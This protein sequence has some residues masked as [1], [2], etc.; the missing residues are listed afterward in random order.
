MP[1]PPPP[2][3]L[4][5]Q[6]AGTS[7]WTSHDGAGEL[8]HHF[9]LAKTAAR[10]RPTVGIMYTSVPSLHP[11]AATDETYLSGDP[12]LNV[13]RRSSLHLRK[14]ISTLPGPGGDS[15][16]RAVRA[17]VFLL[18]LRRDP[19]ACRTSLG[20]VSACIRLEANSSDPSMQRQCTRRSRG[21]GHHHESG[22]Y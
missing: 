4:Y 13:L 6:V 15:V 5:V 20:P 14:I 16:S 2:T 22:W 19:S 8:P 18:P 11:S 7:T 17:F 3:R 9:Y 10:A 12:M 21:S 1:T